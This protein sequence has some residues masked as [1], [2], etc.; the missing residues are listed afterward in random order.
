MNDE[1]DYI[2]FEDEST[3]RNYQAIM[4]TW[5]PTGEQRIIKTYGKHEGVKLTGVIDYESGAVYVEEN[6][7]QSLKKCQYPKSKKCASKF[8]IY[9]I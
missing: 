6:V 9:W 2:L 4:R 1:I 7:W 3:I 8:R 5:F